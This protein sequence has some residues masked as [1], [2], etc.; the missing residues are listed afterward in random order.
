MNI[1]IMTSGGGTTAEAFIRAGARGKIETEVGLVICNNP[2]AGIL[3][4]VEALN[5]ELDLTI[6]T[7]VINSRT[8]P[9]AGRMTPGK[10]TE[11]EESA[12]LDAIKSGNF[13][14]VA[15]M[16]YMKK[17]GPRLVR[18]FGWQTDYTDSRE[19]M[20]VNTH[21]GLLPETKGFIGVHVQ[22]HVIKKKLPYGGQTL[23][24]VAENYDDGPIIAE[25]RIKVEPEDTPE[26]LFN[27]VRAV[28]KKYLPRDIEDF[29][30]SR[31]TYL[32]GTRHG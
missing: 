21:P 16:G 32:K 7:I 26:S 17:I 5:K 29:I 28:E 12:I 30:K 22:E 20:M 11:A 24:V 10:Q 14:L 13:G 31:Q 2:K 9:S 23:H 25:H 6:K 18:E 1:V 19:A 15:L 8:H 27:R 3:E 4:R